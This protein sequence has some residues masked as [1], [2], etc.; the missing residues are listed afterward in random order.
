MAP[1]LGLSASTISVRQALDLLDG[2]FAGLA[3]GVA[4]SRYAFWLGSGISR[5]RVDDLK[6]VVARVPRYLRER[7]DPANADCPFGR[8]LSEALGL[9]R[10]SP[11]DR[12]TIDLDRPIEEWPVIDTVLFN[13]TLEYSRLLDIRIEGEEADFLLWEVVDVPTTFA[14]ARSVP[15][16]EHLCLGIL[17]LEGLLADIATANWDG[18]VEAAIEELTA[19]SGIALRVCVTANDLREPQLLSRLLKFHGCAVRAGDDPGQYRPMLIAR[20]SQITDWPHNA[21]YALMRNHL[22]SLAATKPTLM[23]GLSAQDTNIQFIF[24]NARAQMEWTWP[25][26]PPAH[27]FAEDV[28]G[29]DQR[30]ILRVVYRDAYD[31]NMAAIEASALFRAYAKPALTAL[32]LHVICT[33]LQTLVCT[34]EAPLLPAAERIPIE[35]GIKRLRDKVAL[36]AEPDRL[37]F[38]RMLIA[39][40]SQVMALFQ[41]GTP[42]PAGTSSYRAISQLPIQLIG[43]DPTLATSGTRELACTLG[44]LGLGDSSASWS[45]TGSDPS[46]PATGAVRLRSA[47]G[48]TRVFFAAND[49]AGINL[50]INGL[51][52]SDDP[53]TVVVH[54]TSPVPG[55]PRSPKAAP[56]R[57]GKAGARHVGMAELLREARSANELFGRFREEAAV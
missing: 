8:A 48:D 12:A 41:Q 35:Q 6:Q 15:D 27:I 37:R 30:N 50:E 11:A 13:L 14:P 38:I 25:C 45:V 21:A 24:S 1:V 5:D 33:K 54:S 57:V 53:D 9:A 51:A 19:G 40:Q 49:R 42:A 10:L 44:L 43:G 4:E 18:L 3:R 46:D 20:Y 26:D 56:G 52:T 36:L 47:T 39:A 16:C 2:D 22:V 28:L 7:R 34:A 55:M 23:I 29:Q 32:V 17:I 31:A